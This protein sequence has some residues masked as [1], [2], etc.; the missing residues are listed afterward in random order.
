MNS[1]SNVASLQVYDIFHIKFHFL[2]FSFLLI[3]SIKQGA[4]VS[5]HIAVIL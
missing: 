3:F 5:V 1:T 4:E 2:V